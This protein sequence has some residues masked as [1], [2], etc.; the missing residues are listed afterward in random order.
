MVSLSLKDRRETPDNLD[1]EPPEPHAL[2][3]SV[4]TN[5]VHSVVPIAASDKR[6]SMLPYSR[7]YLEGAETM[8]KD[9]TARAVQ[10]R[11]E[12]RLHLSFTKRSSSKER[13]LF[14]QD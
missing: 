2:S 12:V 11:N 4:T 3:T 7:G 14:V 10:V 6:E 9:R 8:L 5:L 13:N 1:L